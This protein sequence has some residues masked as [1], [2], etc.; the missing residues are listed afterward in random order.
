MTKS[1]AMNTTVRSAK[2]ARIWSRLSTPVKY[3]ASAE[4]IATISTAT[5]FDTKRTTLANRMRNVVVA[6]LMCRVF[7]P[8]AYRRIG[9]WH[10]TGWPLRGE[11]ARRS[12]LGLAARRCR[13]Q[14]C[15]SVRTRLARRSGLDGARV[16][17]PDRDARLLHTRDR[18]GPAGGAG[19][20]LTPDLQPS[21]ARCGG[22]DFQPS[23]RGDF[24]DRAPDWSRPVDREAIAVDGHQQLLASP[25]HAGL[26]AVRRIARDDQRGDGAPG[27]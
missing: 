11:L 9:G 7:V 19:A 14:S 13:R 4:P 21:Q 6:W 26:S 23:P 16:Q 15:E 20:A 2:P 10:R 18:A 12:S 1:V 27:W 3:R 17:F 5:R 22:H 24:L 25:L 8:E